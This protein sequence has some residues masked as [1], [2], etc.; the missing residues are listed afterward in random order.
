M[1]YVVSAK[2]VGDASSLKAA[3]VEGKAAIADVGAAAGDAG[4]KASTAEKPIDQLARGFR[5]VA[6]GARAQI[7][8]VRKAAEEQDRARAASASLGTT[9]RS[10][11]AAAA[12]EATQVRG[13]AAA[14]QQARSTSSALGATLQSTVGTFAQSAA[15]AA[16]LGGS[17]TQT[18]VNVGRFGAIIGT[19]A[20]A[21]G[22]AFGMAVSGAVTGLLSLATSF[23]DSGEAAED[24]AKSTD[25]HKWSAKELTAAIDELDAAMKKQ[26]QTS[27]QAEWQ[28]FK[29]AEGLMTEAK[30]RRDVAKAA[31]EQAAADLVAANA[32]SIDPTLAGEGGFN[33]GFAQG[34]LAAGQI[35]V[36]EA[37]IKKL[38]ADTAKAEKAY[39]RSALPILQR[40]VAEATDK[41]ARINGDYE[42]TLARLDGELTR[43][44]ITTGKYRQELEK[45]TK[46]RDAAL[47]TARR[48]EQQAKRTGRETARTVAFLDPVGGAVNSGFGLRRAPK[49]GAS[50]FHRGVDF[51]ADAGTPV[52]APAVGTVEAVGFDPKL[53]KYVVID[54][55]ARTKTKYGHLSDNTVRVGTQL[56]AGEVFARSGN[57]GNSTGP[58]LHY[59]VIR[60]GEYVD[61]LKRRFPV[62]AG[63]AALDTEGDVARESKRLAAEARREADE[64]RRAIEELER[65]LGVVVGAFDPARA[66]AEK[67]ADQLERIADLHRKGFLSDG[68]AISLSLEASRQQAEAQRKADAALIDRV[69]GGDFAKSWEES[70]AQADA[71]VGARAAAALEKAGRRGGEAFE[72]RGTQAAEAI[73]RLLG[74]K[75]G[76]ALGDAFGIVGGLKSGNFNSVGGPLGSILTLLGSERRPGDKPD[77]FNEGLG[78]F[79]KPLKG[80]F[81][82]VVTKIGDTFKIGGDFEKTLG[83]VAGGAALGAVVGPTVTKLLGIRGSKTGATIGGA[84][85]SAAGAASG[86]PGGEQIGAVVGS[87]YGSIV[88]GL[89]KKAKTGSATITSTTG[90]LVVGGNHAGSKEAA[91]TLGKNIQSALGQIAEQLGGTLGAFSVSIGMKDGKYRVDPTGKGVVKTKK[92]A[93][94]F[95]EDQ[96]A[97]T[98][99]ALAD[100]LADGAV[101]GLS[102]K[103]QAALRS[104][105]DVDRALREAI[106]VDELETLLQG[107]GGTMARQFKDFDRVAADRVRIARQFGFDV[108]KVEKLNA[109]ERVKLT[110]RILGSRVGVLKELISS[111]DFGDLFEGSISDQIARLKEEAGKARADA[112]AGLEGAAE[113]FAGLERSIIEKTM[114]GFGTAGPE[115]AAARKDARSSAERIIELENARVKAA[116]DATKETNN[117]LNELNDQASEQTTVLRTIERLLKG[118]LNGGGGG[119]PPNPG[120]STR[121]QGSLS[122]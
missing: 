116:Q 79:I 22:G 28:S 102:E 110:E 108:L 71:R 14:H 105:K 32:S 89:F 29:A 3:A 9:L 92:G 54:H 55:G 59:S 70:M 18:G 46:A 67:Y 69:T 40:Q 16:G 73:A 117:Q 23:F 112:E 2:L 47:E 39:T 74:G 78:E 49:A 52:R 6:M 86:I 119:E 84:I 31:L 11:A 68:Q 72:S 27:Q 19:V 66:A 100:A 34:S 95:G 48:E 77:P 41:T 58:H 8:E 87:I 42:R 30:R 90:D 12:A 20:G 122:L 75:V 57:T 53:G 35:R 26:T 114:E 45:A 62:S 111:I 88:G 80:G 24:S 21:L 101:I 96:A 97:A 109:E 44:T 5:E 13:S 85:G 65:A 4:R 91:S 104:T 98:A 94:D 83:H 51:Q 113:R 38:D 115:L 15:G 1:T 121:F 120:V 60:G 17:V 93:L 36:L 76:D 107:L 50:T 106:K 81:K 43:H 25:L 10:T 64:A 82:D 33:P 99:A 103:V 56:A 61:P 118:I 63:D 37:Q 7:V